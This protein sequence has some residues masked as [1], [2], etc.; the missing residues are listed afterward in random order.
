MSSL[1]STLK[2]IAQH[3]LNRRQPLS[4]IARFAHW[5]VES[6]LRSQVEFQWIDDAKLVVE[7][8][9]TGATG[10]I[11][12]GLHEFADMAFAMHLLRP[13]DLFVDVGANIGS[14]T[15]LASAVSGARVIA[16][17]PDP[18]TICSLNKNILAN[19][20][21]ERVTL[22]EAA[23]GAESGTANFTIGRG[24]QNQVANR[25]LA[26]TRH[27]RIQKLDNALSGLDPILI[28][29]DVEGYESQV[30][31][32]GRQTLS[33]PSLLAVETELLD[34][35]VASQ[36]ENAGFAQWFYDPFTRR[37]SQE[38]CSIS[39]SNALF[40]KDVDFCQR[41]LDAAPK[42]TILGVEI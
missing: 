21:S 39:A 9:M 32:G 10:N 4:A 37:L 24:C 29:L 22:V 14:Y 6:R 12:C 25:A 34:E 23:L 8:G 26:S 28:K 13:N 38:P 5:Q 41:R 7:R 30:L 19:G 16:F 35:T 36:L 31:A 40:L 2:F 15:V 27:V 33:R 17:E 11:Y 20:V 1:I 18:D 42:R 3:P